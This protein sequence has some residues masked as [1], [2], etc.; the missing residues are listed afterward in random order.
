MKK[1]KIIDVLPDDCILHIFSFLEFD[2]LSKLIEKVKP[3]RKLLKNNIRTFSILHF[4]IPRSKIK[5][6]EN[7]LWLYTIDRKKLK[8]NKTLFLLSVKRDGMNLMDG[9]PEL[10][11]DKEVVME[12]VK[13]KGLALHYASDNLKDDKN[14]VME[15][16][17]NNGYALRH[18]SDNLRNDKEVVM[19]A[20]KNKG[21]AL[22]DAADNLKDD[23]EVVMEA[24]KNDWDSMLYASDNLKDELIKSLYG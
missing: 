22:G 8:A 1:I 2:E 13:N 6:I 3:L 9:T 20:V 12:A 24:V 23:R 21:D 11:N 17:K 7:A 18:A 10:R 5:K 16:V 15:I 19:E 14:F 4:G